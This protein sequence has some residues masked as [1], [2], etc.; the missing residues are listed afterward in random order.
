MCLYVCVFTQVQEWLCLNC[1][2]QRAL[3]MDMTTP[4]SKSQQQIHASKP[5]CTIPPHSQSSAQ[6]KSQTQN[7]TLP[8]SNTQPQIQSQILLSSQIMKGFAE[9]CQTGHNMGSTKENEPSQ[10]ISQG[11]QSCTQG[12]KVVF[13]EKSPTRLVQTGPR[14]PHSG[15]VPLPGLTKVPSQPE[16]GHSYPGRSEQI[17]S[18]RSSPARRPSSVHETPSQDGLTKLFGF[19]A[20]LLNQAS[21]LI[22]VDPLPGGGTPPSRQQA[23]NGAKVVF[24]DAKAKATT[25]VNGASQPGMGETT[26]YPGTHTPLQK[27]LLIQQ[28]PNYHKIPKLSKKEPQQQPL[29]PQQKGPQHQ[30]LAHQQKALQQQIQTHQQK[31]PQSQSP[32]LQQ[33]GPQSLVKES[34]KPKVSCPLCNTELKFGSNEPPNYNSCTQCHTKV[35]F[36]CG[37]NPAPHLIEVNVHPHTDIIIEYIYLNT[38]WFQT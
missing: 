23:T 10:N 16:L 32:A 13:G 4:C 35:C 14:I 31:G 37:F 34:S 25:G 5:D 24:S 9:S 6:L 29:T 17:Q 27:Q 12:H 15:A 26:F 7:H 11:M 1:Q 2:M 33:K 30:S 20:S 22:S 36:M 19:G 3:G 38:F 8:H 18:A 21:T 28:Q